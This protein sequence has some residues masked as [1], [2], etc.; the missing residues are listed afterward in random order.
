MSAPITQ[1]SLPSD[2][3]PTHRALLLTCTSTPPTVVTVPIPTLTP[4]SA[5]IAPLATSVLNYTKSV[6]NGSLDYRFPTPFVP[7]SNS[8]ARIV[9]V[10]ADATILKPGQLVVYDS[11]VRARDDPSIQILMGL[12]GGT[13]ESFKLMTGEWRDGTYA[14]FARVPLESCYPINEEKLVKGMGYTVEELTGMFR[15]MVSYGGISD[16]ELKVGETVIVS[17]ATGNFGRAAVDMCLALGCNVVAFGRNESVLQSVKEK[18]KGRVEIVKI[19]GNVEADAE[20]LKST[21]FGEPHA[22]FDIS[23]PSSG[24]AT[25][26]KSGILALRHSGRVSLMGGIRD[27]IALPH[28]KVMRYCLKICGRWMYTRENVQEMIRMV[29][30]G[31]LQLRRGNVTAFKLEDALEAFDKAEEW[32][33][34][35]AERGRSA[36]IVP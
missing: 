11:F 31:L 19:S 13:E 21:R 27:E 25:Y 6:H 2:Y 29:E 33:K 26:L 12:S 9:A 4:G 24:P 30:G 15:L 8:I 28:R 10:G 18:G 20:I 36:V 14:E 17:P 32:G 3:P 7:G 1:P 34:G 22:F 35:G 5:I 23:P 16:L